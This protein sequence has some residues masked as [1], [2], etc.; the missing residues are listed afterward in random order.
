V[1]PYTY[2]LREAAHN[3]FQSLGALDDLGPDLADTV[4]NV[5]YRYAL[6]TGT[7]SNLAL[8]LGTGEGDNLEAEIGIIMVQQE[9]IDEMIQ[10]VRRAGH[11][12]RVAKRMKLF[13]LDTVKY[14]IA[15]ASKKSAIRRAVERRLA[16]V[17]EIAGLYERMRV[18]LSTDEGT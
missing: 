2:A 17:G 6:V 10:A 8:A 11:G 13:T 5:Y 9:Y 14:R 1:D 18:L 4:A 7:V 12:T 16:N 15:N 3:L